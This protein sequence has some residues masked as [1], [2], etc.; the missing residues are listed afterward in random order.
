MEDSQTT[1]FALMSDWPGEEERDG[2]YLFPNSKLCDVISMWSDSLQELGGSFSHSR[3]I[4]LTYR[5][6]LSFHSRRGHET[7]K[8]AQLLAHQ[9]LS[10][11]RL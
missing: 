6:R 11:I 2:F 3:V 9:V 8:E 10:K 7:D 4:Q 1:G 5:N